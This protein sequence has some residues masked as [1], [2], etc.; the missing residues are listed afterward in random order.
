MIEF[1]HC[2]WRSLSRVSYLLGVMVLGGCAIHGDPAPRAVAVPAAW[3]AT[4]KQVGN[5]VTD[6]WWRSFGSVELDALVARAG[7]QSLDLAEAAARMQEAQALARIAGASMWPSLSA[8]G[9]ASR[10][11]RLGGSTDV[12]GNAWQLG[13]V[14]NYEVD[15]WG[16]L[17]ALRETAGREVQASAFDLD[18]VRLTVTANV[19]SA[20]VQRQATRERIAI[21]EQ[22]LASADRVLRLVEARRH[23]GA[24]LQLELAQQR[25]LVAAQRRTIE[26]LRQ[27]QDA[28]NMAIAALLGEVVPLP[29]STDATLATLQLPDI[30]PDTP[31]SLL[32][33]RPDIAA[34]EARLA[35]ADANLDAARAALFPTVSLGAGLGFAGTTLGTLFS[36]PAYT[37]AAALAAPIFD[38][39]RL[40]GQRD[41]AAAQRTGQLVRY[42]ATIVNAFADAETALSNV[43]GAD[44]Q[45]REQA[46]ELTQS[47]RAVSLAESRYRAGA[48]TLLNLLISQRS[49]YTAQDQAVQRLEARLLARVGVYRALGGGWGTMR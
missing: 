24:A 31:S 16:R 21:G 43:N 26:A 49:Y 44:A 2:G 18:T 23:A 28:L 30:T 27:Q 37:L 12:A 9:R 3:H 15:L 17:A 45:A 48:D 22:N 4:S 25:A 32:A 47:E 10:Q 34:A 39:G 35:A 11:G 38:G 1:P 14:A 5:D 6:A 42:R 20:W 40:A 7:Q 41:L 13:F 36:G 19:A 33:R 8:D 29:P 46:E